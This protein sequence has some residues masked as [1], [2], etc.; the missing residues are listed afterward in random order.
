MITRR[1]FAGI[2]S[3]NTRWVTLGE[4]FEPGKPWAIDKKWRAGFAGHASYCIAASAS[5][6]QSFGWRTDLQACAV[7]PHIVNAAIGSRERDV[8]ITRFFRNGHQ[9]I[10]VVDP[11]LT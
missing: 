8:F 10:A 3:S 7:D 2:A 1:R 5:R 9:H 4:V 6:E 11:S